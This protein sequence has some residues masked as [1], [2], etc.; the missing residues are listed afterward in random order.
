MIGTRK[1]KDT[2]TQASKDPAAI[3]RPVLVGFRAVHVFDVSQTEGAELPD[4]KE[5]VKGNLVC[6]ANASRLPHRP[7]HPT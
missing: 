3:N 2:K 4:L 7:G 6:T 1:K 5:R